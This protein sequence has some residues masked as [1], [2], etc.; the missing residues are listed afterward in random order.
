MGTSHPETKPW[1]VQRIIDS[2]ARHVLDVGAGAGGWADALLA[3][4]YK[5]TLTAVEVWEPYIY[6]FRLLERYSVVLQR[7]VRHIEP[8][9]FAAYDVVIFGDVLE[10]MTRDE[11]LQ[12]WDR[13][14]AA[15]HAAIAIPIIHYCQGA[16][17]DNPY[18]EHVVDNWAHDTVLAAFP[19]ITDS[20]AFTITGAYWR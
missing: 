12:V 1:V 18:E 2:G 16:L 6:A 17:N 8:E 7:D 3:A 15:P 20:Q 14:G 19:G 10:H 4:G 13:A 9:V 11:A 5:G